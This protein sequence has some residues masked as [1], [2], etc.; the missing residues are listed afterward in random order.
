MN[1]AIHPLQFDLFDVPVLLASPPK[2]RLVHSSA[3]AGQ[4]TKRAH[5]LNA[6]V[7]THAA[8]KSSSEFRKVLAMAKAHH[9]L[10]LHERS[11]FLLTQL[12]RIDAVAATEYYETLPDGHPVNNLWHAFGEQRTAFCPALFAAFAVIAE[13]CLRRVVTDDDK[14]LD[15]TGSLAAACRIM[16][17]R[18]DSADA[19]EACKAPIQG[20]VSQRGD[21][22]ARMASVSLVSRPRQ[23]R[24]NR[25]Q[26]TTL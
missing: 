6:C 15:S 21:Y 9:S 22:A 20:D 3:L 8:L 14:R 7:L 17:A 11:L 23:A 16:Q 19:P 13:P 5:K 25:T 24:Q 2:P 1:A 18:I 4:K 10:G 26:A 12:A